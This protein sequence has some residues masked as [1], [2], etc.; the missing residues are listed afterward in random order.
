MASW[1]QQ[2]A[3][4][5]LLS[6][7]GHLGEH[8]V[9]LTWDPAAGILQAPAGLPSQRPPR[10]PLLVKLAVATWPCWPVPT[11]TWAASVPVASFARIP[12]DAV[13]A[14]R[15]AVRDPLLIVPP[16]RSAL[17]PMA[18]AGRGDLSDKLAHPSARQP[19]ALGYSSLTQRLPGRDR[20]R[21][22][23]PDRLLHIAWHL[24]HGWHDVRPP[25]SQGR[26]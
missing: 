7:H 8:L 14:I 21:V 26:G 19:K 16:A 20:R 24:W 15:E 6:Q 13:P 1:F 18:I 23:R 25:W 12:H 10:L 3:C 5:L 17:G 22:G 4:N 2:S 11:W 9:A